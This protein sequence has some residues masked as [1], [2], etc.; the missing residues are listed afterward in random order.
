MTNIGTLNV[1]ADGRH[2]AT[3]YLTNG[4][5]TAH[6]SVYIDNNSNTLAFTEFNV[7]NGYSITFEIV[8]V[9]K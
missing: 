2:Y 6:R 4:T 9:C 8:F 3:A 1:K 5:D 7:P